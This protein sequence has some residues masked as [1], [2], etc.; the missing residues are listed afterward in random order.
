MTFPTSNDPVAAFRDALSGAGLPAPDGIA[1]DGKLHRFSTNGRAGDKAGWYVLHADGAVPAGA[2]GCWRTGIE[3]K[4]RGGKSELTPAER[5]DYKAQLRKIKRQKDAERRARHAEAAKQAAEIWQALEPA[6]SHPYLEAKGVGAHGV[7][8]DDD[9]ILVVPVF[10]DGELSSLQ[11]IDAEGG[12]QFLPG[13]K[14][15]GGYFAIGKPAERLYI[16]EGYATG[17]SIFE[18]TGQ[19]A[20][21]AFNAKNLK[22]VAESLRVKF[23][24]LE[25]VVAADNDETG[26]EAAQEAATAAGCAVAVPP[27]GTSGTDWND[28]HHQDGLEALAEALRFTPSNNRATVQPLQAEPPELAKNPRILA[29]FREVVRGCG[30]VGEETTAATVYL[31]LTSRLLDKPVS[32]AVKGHSSSGKSYTTEAVVKFFPPEAVM[33]MTAMSERALVYSEDDY[34]HKTIII[35]EATALREGAE[36]NMTAYFVRSLLSEGRIEYPVTVKEDG[37]FVTRTIIKEGPC[38][39]IVTTTKTRLHAENETRLLSLATND[40]REQTASIFMALA[41]ET[42]AGVD[43][44]EWHQLQSWLQHANH[45]V[46]IPYARRLAE[47]VP[48][49]AIR[50][51]RDFGAVLAL[52][53]A[54]AILHQQTR[55]RDDAGRIVAT[56]DDYGEVRGMVGELVAE[57]VGSTVKDV[58]R[59]TVQ[60]VEKTAG[61][62]GVTAREVAEH[63]NLDK[64]TVSRRLRMA[65]EEGYLRNMEDKRGKPG[66][67]VVGEPLPEK[68]DVLPQP[69]NLEPPE[70]RANTSGCTVAEGFQG[71]KKE[72]SGGSARI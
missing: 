20:A 69:H 9:G 42:D 1:A 38:N 16:A 18:A 35:Y 57:G 48:P 39:M 7:K 44:D 72:G 58:V 29:K 68:V 2:F 5:K 21:I 65:A 49:L 62:D 53:R 32:A 25:M 70:A 28:Y 36:D 3:Q 56:V 37:Q 23:P 63:L 15:K 11:F 43:L 47:L 12:K 52:I 19:A 27:E 45:N 41:D 30:V 10:V 61:R 22:P 24:D 6:S 46:T 71:D 33:V 67:W 14:T 26:R 50:L 59:E 13:G 60:A 51:R 4:W 40:S 66:R 17:G 64:G 54:H 8:V 34:S 31:L 55:E